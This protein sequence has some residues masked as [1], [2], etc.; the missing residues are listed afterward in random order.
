MKR[1]P[2][3]LLLLILTT[4]V[5]SR[6]QSDT[7]FQGRASYY[8]SKFNGRKTSSGEI[9]RNDSLTAAHKYLPFG[10]RVKVTSVKTEKSV[11]VRI[12]DRLPQSSK[13]LIDLS[14]SAARELDMIKRGL[15]N[16]RVEILK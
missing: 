6:Q 9:F 5:H 3:L 11:I 7:L 14:Q 1:S 16:V 8:A 15:E 10:T 12:N 13:R 4:V 2:I